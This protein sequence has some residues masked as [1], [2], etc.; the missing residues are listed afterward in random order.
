MAKISINVIESSSNGNC[1]LLNDGE[2]SLFLDFGSD[3]KN[4]QNC[5]NLNAISKNSIVGALITH[6]HI[7]HTRAINS[8][9]FKNIPFYLTKGTSWFFR[10]VKRNFINIKFNKWINLANS[11]WKFKS[12]PIQHNAIEPACFL[13]KNKRTKILYLTDTRYFVNMKFKG[14][15]CYIIESNYG[16]E[17]IESKIKSNIHNDCQNRSHLNLKENE[18]LFHKYTTRK[19]KLYLMSHLSSKLTDDKLISLVTKRLQEKN[20]WIEV[21]YIDPNKINFYKWSI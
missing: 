11:N 15:N 13:I 2:T 21:E 19:T 9:I 6:E 12:F 8:D 4:I 7:D 3:Y 14:C 1:I 20:K 16:C 10:G 5:L 17:I 18:Q